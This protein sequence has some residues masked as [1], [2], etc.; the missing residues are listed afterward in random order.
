[1]LKKS[2]EIAQFNK[3]SRAIDL[4]RNIMDNAVCRKNSNEAD[5]DNS[6]AYYGDV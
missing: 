1:M 4:L 2:K 5:V 6:K 3:V